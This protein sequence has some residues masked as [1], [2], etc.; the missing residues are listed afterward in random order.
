MLIAC[1]SVKGGSGTSVVA[2]SLALLLSDSDQGAVLADLDGDLPAVLGLPTPSGPGLGDWLDAGP[3]VPV[4]G[5][6]RLTVD[7]RPGLRLVPWCGQ[8]EADTVDA[9]RLAAELSS[10]FGSANVV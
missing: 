5:L 6:R 10:T 3:D 9:A 7:V 8:P 4:D 2:A 1:W